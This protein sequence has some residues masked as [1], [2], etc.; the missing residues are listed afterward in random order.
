MSISQVKLGSTT[1]DIVAGGITY[2]TCTTTAAIAAKEATVVSGNFT[3]FT[4]A[5]V[6][7]KFTNS[8]SAASPTLKIGNT[9]AKPI[10][11]YGSTAAGTTASTTGWAAGAI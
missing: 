9:N 4:G 5:T 10:V 1:H 7:V 3:L 6:V 11:L 2:C 8:N